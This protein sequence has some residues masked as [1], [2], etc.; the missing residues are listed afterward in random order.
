MK[1]L[2]YVAALFLLSTATAA[3]DHV[4]I[5]ININQ[6]NFFPSAGGGQGGAGLTGGPPGA[7]LGGGP[8]APGGLGGGLGGGPGAP[9]GLGGGLGGGPGAPGGFGGLGGGPGAPG[10]LGGGLG[11][12]GGVPGQA[13]GGKGGTTSPAEDPNAKW[14]F[15]VVELNYPLFS[16]KPAQIKFGGQNSLLF[17]Y[18]HKWGRNNWLPVSPMLPIQIKPIETKSF[19]KEFD[20]KFNAEKND[21]KKTV[22]NFLRLA[23]WTLSRGRSAEFHKVMAEAEKL[24]ASHPLVKNYQRVKQDL[25]RAF[26]SDDPAQTELLAEI[27]SRN[28]AKVDSDRGH[29]RM[30]YTP[31]AASDTATKASV[32]R[33]LAIMEE[34]LDTFYYFF[35]LQ[36]KSPQPN[37]PRYRLNS[38]LTGSSETFKTEQLKWGQSAMVADGF[39]PRRDNLV[40]MSSKARIDDPVY[41][42]FETI[43]NA[44]LDEART[45]LKQNLKI[46]VSR[47]DLLSG[48]IAENKMARE[49]AAFF[50]GIA[51]TAV[52]VS[53]A[54]D[55]GAERHTVTNETTRQLLIASAMFPR[56]VQIPDWMVDGLA[57][58]FE[59]P[60]NALFPTIG[61]PSWT[62][63]VSFKH[64]NTGK[65]KRFSSPS[66]TLFNVLTDTYFQDARSTGK[67]ALENRSNEDLQRASKES[68][69]LARCTS[70]AFVYY[71]AQTRKLECLFNYGKELSNLPRDM[72]LNDQVL[73]ACFGKAFGLTDARDSRRIDTINLKNMAGAWFEMMQ[74]TNLENSDAQTTFGDMRAKQDT[75]PAETKGTGSGNTGPK[76]GPGFPG[77]GPGKGGP[78]LPGGGGP[79]GPGL[80]GGGGPGNPGGGGPGLPGGGGPGGPGLPGGGGPGGPGLPGGGGPGGPGLPGGGGPGGPGLPG[81]GGPGGPGLP[82]GGG[83][84][85]PGG[86]GPGLP[87]GGG[88][89]GRS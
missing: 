52:V 25:K 85:N 60:S 23:R 53:K 39:T 84:G 49:Q 47:E 51:Q 45:K 48:K 38:L 89:A 34:T 29:F 9:G 78:G 15:A 8:G 31:N 11:L 59:T 40:V 26:D 73:Q 81:G 72:D 56:N 76:G 1:K 86:G 58:L 37:L 70:W 80:P 17:A 61:S 14:V 50:I 87:G 10:G 88:P 67:E 57:A 65:N 55:E 41:Q 35:A 2:L 6:L 62:H 20:A 68:W 3:A 28:S 74:G 43:L 54:L 16:Q 24:D 64:F 19:S 36:E 77:G 27:K 33:R 18:S 71:L 32:I 63:L 22:D 66:E 83:P 42:E 46:D 75:K 79:G 12:G 7:G 5:K 69:E 4:L 13:N 30:Y 82:G 44:K 21:K